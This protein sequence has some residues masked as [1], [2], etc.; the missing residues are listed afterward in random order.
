MLGDERFDRPQDFDL[1][2]YWVSYLDDFRARCYIGTATVRLS[3]RECWRLLGNVA[4][5]VVRAFGSTATAGGDDGWVEAVIPVEGTEHACCELLRLGGMS[6]SL[7][8]PNSARPWPPPQRHSPEPTRTRGQVVRRWCATPGE[9][10]AT[11]NPQV[12]DLGVRERAGD[13][14]R[15]R[16]LSLGINGS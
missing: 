7:H 2:V 10:W 15:T 16:A 4:L 13:E 5:A 1:G 14:N 9:V 3:P 6:R 11:T 12:H 8:G